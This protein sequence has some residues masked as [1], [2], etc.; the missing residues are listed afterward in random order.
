[1]W[2]LFP[3]WQ[4][5]LCDSGWMD[6][7]HFNCDT[8]QSKCRP[9]RLRAQSHDTAPHF[10]CQLRVVGP[11]VTHNFWLTWLQIGG[12]H[13][14]P[15]WIQSLARTAHRTQGNTYIGLPV[16]YIIKVT[17][18]DTHGHPDGEVPRPW[19]GRVPAQVLLSPRS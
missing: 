4:V 2:G 16:Y 13:H 3:P 9:H 6:V 10:R 12:S 11:R 1:M 5:I 14:P 15:P 18:K 7:P 8:N 17:I 19:C